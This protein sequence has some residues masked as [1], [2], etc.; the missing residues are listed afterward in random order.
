MLLTNESN[1]MSWAELSWVESTQKRC[2]DE[3]TY[4]ID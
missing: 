3:A 4:V 1:G 2:Y